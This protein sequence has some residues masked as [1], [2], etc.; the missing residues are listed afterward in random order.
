MTRL[1]KMFHDALGVERDPAQA[2][3]WWRCAAD[4]GDAEGQALHGATLH[5]GA[6]VARDKVAALAWLL[7]A[8]AN[9][10]EKADLFLG[11]VRAALAPAEIAEAERRAAEPLAEPRP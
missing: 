3:R 6:G 11:P 9:G 7:R 2:A 8:R 1:G 10:S 4:R 5:L